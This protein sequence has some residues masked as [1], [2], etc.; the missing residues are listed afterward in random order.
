MSYLHMEVGG[1]LLCTPYTTNRQICAGAATNILRTYACS[2]SRCFPTF[3]VLD[4][5]EVCCGSRCR[6][7][8]NVLLLVTLVVVQSAPWSI[9]IY[10]RSCREEARGGIDTAVGT[11]SC[12]CCFCFGPHGPHP[13]AGQGRTANHIVYVCNTA[14]RRDY[15][16]L[17]NFETYICVC[18]ST[19]SRTGSISAAAWKTPF[20]TC[21]YPCLEPSNLSPAWRA[22]MPHS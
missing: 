5:S 13:T 6:D 14:I 19:A 20:V 12:C 22:S 15:S 18:L 21:C 17:C 2:L 9:G 3:I 10:M 1:L 4:A 11:C 8:S 7:S 16:I